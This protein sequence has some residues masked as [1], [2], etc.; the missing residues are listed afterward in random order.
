[1]LSDC[2][3]DTGIKLGMFLNLPGL[4]YYVDTIY[5]D[6]NRTYRIEK[7]CGPTGIVEFLEFSYT[8]GDAHICWSLLEYLKINEEVYLGINF[9]LELKNGQLRTIDL[10]EGGRGYG[11]HSWIV[12]EKDGS[13]RLL[14]EYF[15]EAS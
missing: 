7:H 15:V 10:W 9:I 5:M 3:I 2:P 1:M 11:T 8:Y 4:D 12:L 13:T 14:S 6:E